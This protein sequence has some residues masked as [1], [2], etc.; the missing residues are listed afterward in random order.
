M[1]EKYKAWWKET[2]SQCSKDNANM[3]NVVYLGMYL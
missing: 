3:V 1:T 2:E